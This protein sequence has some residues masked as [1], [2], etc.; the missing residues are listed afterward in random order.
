LWTFETE[1]E[2]KIKEERGAV[3]RVVESRGKRKEGYK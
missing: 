1:L 3:Y 2:K